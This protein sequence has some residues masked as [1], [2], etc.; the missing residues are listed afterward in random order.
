MGWHARTAY[1]SVD[2]GTIL[3]VYLN[4]QIAGQPEPQLIDRQHIDI[5]TSQG[6]VEALVDSTGL[7]SA[8]LTMPDGVRFQI[9]PRRHDE[10]DSGISLGGRMYSRDW[11]VRSQVI[12]VV[13]PK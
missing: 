2:V 11:I 5:E 3:C 10:R 8:I 9:T 12:P 7:E 13:K 1:K 4:G 6:W